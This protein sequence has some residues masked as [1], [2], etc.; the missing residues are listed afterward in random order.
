MSKV[1]VSASIS[2]DGFGAGPRQSLED[3]Q[4]VGG[5]ALAEWVFGTRTFQS[6]SRRATKCSSGIGRSPGAVVSRC[7]SPE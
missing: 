6:L 5:L 1:K 3:P 7:L 2:I 4:G